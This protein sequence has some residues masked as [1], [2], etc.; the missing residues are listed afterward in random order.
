[1]TSQHR[2]ADQN[3]MAKVM[4]RSRELL[5]RTFQTF[6]DITNR[7]AE[8]YTVNEE[9]KFPAQ[10]PVPSVHGLEQAFD[11]A[12]AAFKSFQDAMS[13]I[14]D[15]QWDPFNSATGTGSGTDSGT[16]SG[17]GTS[18]STSTGD[19]GLVPFPS[20]PIELLERGLDM[21]DNTFRAYKTAMA[22]TNR[23]V[24]V[25]RQRPWK[26]AMRQMSKKPVDVDNMPKLPGRGVPILVPRFGEVSATVTEGPSSVSVSEPSQPGKAHPTGGTGSVQSR[27]A[28]SVPSKSPPPS[29]AKPSAKKMGKKSG[30][31][32][33]TKLVSPRASSVAAATVQGEPSEVSPA[34][35]SKA[36]A[37][38]TS[39]V[40]RR[41]SSGPKAAS[42][43][44][45]GNKSTG[46]PSRAAS[47]K[48]STSKAT[49]RVKKGNKASAEAPSKT[50]KEAAKDGKESGHRGKAPV[51]SRLDPNVSASTDPENKGNP[52]YVSPYAH[53]P[54]NTGDGPSVSPYANRQDTGDTTHRPPYTTPHDTNSSGR[55]DEGG[56]A[57]TTAAS[58]PP[59]K[60]TTETERG[61]RARREVVND[62]AA[63]SSYPNDNHR[64][65]LLA[66]FAPS[67]REKEQGQRGGAQPAK[68]AGEES[69]EGRV[70]GEKKQSLDSLY[71]RR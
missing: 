61:T 48:G 1:M 50:Q 36:P 70:R 19:R 56:S 68:R 37:D 57:D 39:E 14:P 49:G 59:K 7:M 51:Q 26:L 6:E 69:E 35:R 4:D 42:P 23:Q 40:T 47:K 65:T 10:K 44:S 55:R 24:D 34:N 30:A 29:Q 18:T 63:E 41:A 62:S 60:P 12:T 9:G 5:G 15:D 11:G 25:Q 2:E 58:S 54:P 67:N 53:P 43:T 66:M 27:D 13:E 71:A 17:S 38:P 45:E 22:Q 28:D 32:S 64:A 46:T 33:Q 16:N 31:K 3:R 52:A 20:P 8:Q 21:L